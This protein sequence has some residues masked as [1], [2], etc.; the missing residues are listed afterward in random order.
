[1]VQYCGNLLCYNKS[2]D[3]VQKLFPLTSSKQKIVTVRKYPLL[4]CFKSKFLFLKIM[5]MKFIVRVF[6]ERY[7]R[8]DHSLFEVGFR[9]SGHESLIEIK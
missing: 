5:L 2:F 4:L 8:T 7:F 9:Y 6:T 1:M 3:A